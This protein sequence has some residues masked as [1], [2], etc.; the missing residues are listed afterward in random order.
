MQFPVVV[1]EV[2]KLQE[3]RDRDQQRLLEFE[4]EIVRLRLKDDGRLDEYVQSRHAF[5]STGYFRCTNV[6]KGDW[7]KKLPDECSTEDW[8]LCECVV[9]SGNDTVVKSGWAPTTLFPKQTIDDL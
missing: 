3:G 9:F 4:Q 2:T 7:I 1:D 5:D 8:S 6:R